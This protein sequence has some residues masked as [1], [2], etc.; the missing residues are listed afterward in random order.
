M[1]CIT[2]LTNSGIVRT[3]R[4]DAS[5][6]AN[7]YGERI[8]VESLA[9]RSAYPG[10]RCIIPHDQI[11]GIGDEATGKRYL[12]EL[13]I[14]AEHVADLTRSLGHSAMTAGESDP[15][16]FPCHIRLQP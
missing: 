10:R 11:I 4:A 7:G 14:G 15:T 1:S 2:S 8:T 6:H 9:A 5:N 13:I 3:S 16:L 12:L